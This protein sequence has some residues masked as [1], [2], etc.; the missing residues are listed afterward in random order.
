MKKI[1]A[2][3]WGGL[4][5]RFAAMARGRLLLKFMLIVCICILQIICL[6]DPNSAMCY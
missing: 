1:T 6:D 2:P 3:F 5:Q 4:V